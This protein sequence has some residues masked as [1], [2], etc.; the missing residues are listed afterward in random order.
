MK[1]C[2]LFNCLL[3]NFFFCYKIAFSIQVINDKIKYM[4]YIPQKNQNHST[5]KP[6]K[7]VINGSTALIVKGIADC[8][9]GKHD[10]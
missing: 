8:I 1:V 6:S 9:K 3:Y 2:K 4:Y 10:H 7:Y 5:N